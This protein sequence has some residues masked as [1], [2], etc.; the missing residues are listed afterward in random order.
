MFSLCFRV[1]VVKVL[2]DMFLTNTEFVKFVSNGL[3]KVI[4]FYGFKKTLQQF[5]ISQRKNRFW[6]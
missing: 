6:H 1:S 2:Y 3:G 5:S 4:T